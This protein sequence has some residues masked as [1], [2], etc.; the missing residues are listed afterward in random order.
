MKGNSH[1]MLG[2]DLKSFEHGAGGGRGQIAE[3]IA[4][5]AFEARNSAC[6]Q[7]LEL[8][9]VV[10]RKE[11]IEAVIDVRLRCCLLLASKRRR[12]RGRRIDIRHFKYGGDAAPGGS[13]GAGL[14]ILLM[15]VAGFAE[16]DLCIDHTGQDVKPAAIAHLTCGG[17]RQIAERRNTPT[18]K[19]QDRVRPPRRD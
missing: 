1:A 18:P 2:D 14:P 4:H 7:R 11:P 19:R 10:L 15:G 12:R 13:R 3:G 17:T 16:M 9:D 5:E 6:D 8:I